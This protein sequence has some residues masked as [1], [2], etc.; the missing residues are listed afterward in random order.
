M[1][2]LIHHVEIEDK[3]GSFVEV[4][5]VSDINIEKSIANL[6]DT[7]TVSFAIF[8]FNQHIFIK[9]LPDEGNQLYKLFKRGQK[10]RIFLG[11]NEELRLEFVGYIKDITTDE[12]GAKLMCEDELFIFREK[13]IPNK[14]F[15]PANVKQIANYVCRLINPKI[16]VVCEYDMGY[17]KFTIID[18]TGFDV[19]SQL[20]QDTGANIF[21]KSVFSNAIGNTVQIDESNFRDQLSGYEYQISSN[22]SKFKESTLE[23]HISMPYMKKNTEAD[24]AFS[25]QHNIETGQLQYIDSKDNKVKVK[26]TS[27]SINGEIRTEEFGSTGGTEKEFK[28]NRLSKAEMKKRAKME[29]F[30][31]MQPHYTGTFDC[32]LIPYVEPNYS[33]IIDDEDFPEKDGVY[34]VDSVTTSF[35]EAGGRRTITPGIKL[36]V[37]EKSKTDKSKKENEK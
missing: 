28:V 22:N 37:D 11:Y 3:K 4:P 19:L 13:N 16:K 8:N 21:F 25:F 31:L 1:F 2:Q 5:F 14:T 15:T 26:V 20:Q 36:S 27:V 23:L 10:I 18:A 30:K 7:A 9:D 12:T 24:C 17:E 35:S 33:I 32:W 29:H 34:N 6:A